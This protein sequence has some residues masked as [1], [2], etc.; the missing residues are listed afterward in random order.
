[1]S[2]HR[3]GMD[4][5]AVCEQLHDLSSSDDGTYGKAIGHGFSEERQVR[6][7]VEVR[8]SPSDSKTKA[9]YDLIEDG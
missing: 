2:V 6:N 1:M 4:A 9:R 7:D 3:S 5:P 8:L